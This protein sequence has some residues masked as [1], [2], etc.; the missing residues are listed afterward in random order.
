[1]AKFLARLMSAYLFTERSAAWEPFGT[2]K[3]LAISQSELAP[4]QTSPLS[5]LRKA[6]VLQLTKSRHGQAI[7]VH[8]AA[9]GRE[10]LRL[11]PV[12]RARRSQ[13]FDLAVGSGQQVLFLAAVSR[14][15]E[16]FQNANCAVRQTS[17]KNEPLVFRKAI[18]A[19]QKPPKPIVPLHQA[20]S[21]VAGQP[22]AECARFKKTYRTPAAGA[23]DARKKKKGKGEK[24]LLEPLPPPQQHATGDDRQHSR[25]WLRG[26]HLPR[27]IRRS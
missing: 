12:E 25:T 3:E 4:T 11:A 26:Q 23:A 16:Q 21:A 13:H 5:R 15:D 14:F 8:E 1:M 17:P 18:N 2:V 6:N 9:I 7:I 10:Y 20:R 24:G 19:I 27:G 22:R